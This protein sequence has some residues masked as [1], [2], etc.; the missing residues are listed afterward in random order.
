MK[1]QITKERKKIVITQEK[2]EIRFFLLT[3]LFDIRD[4]LLTRYVSYDFN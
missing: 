3:K 4:Y 2:K 1:E